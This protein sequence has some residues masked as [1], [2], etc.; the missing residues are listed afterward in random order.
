MKLVLDTHALVW[1]VSSPGE[2]SR[3]AARALEKALN[4]EALVFASSVSIWEIGMLMRKGRL[5]LPA[6]LSDWVRTVEAIPLLRFEPVGNSVAVDSVQLPDFT[7][8][9]PADRLIVATARALDATLI[10]KDQVLRRYRH[11]RSLW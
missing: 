6:S 5:A 1:W 11:V 8:P 7:H 10:T 4:D 3:K 9:D 2:L